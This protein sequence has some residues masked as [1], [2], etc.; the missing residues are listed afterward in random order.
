STAVSV[1]GNL[2]RAPTLAISPPM[3]LKCPHRERTLAGTGGNQNERTERPRAY[4]PQRHRRRTVHQ[5]LSGCGRLPGVSVSP[6]RNG[7]LFDLRRR[8]SQP[9]LVQSAG[10]GP[11]PT[12]VSDRAE[13][14]L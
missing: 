10:G 14:T 8:A 11:A 9:R 4:R 2:F 12:H 6:R 1:K 13:V 7:R 5:I 3:Q